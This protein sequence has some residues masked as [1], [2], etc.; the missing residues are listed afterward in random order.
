LR[1]LRELAA[2]SQ[3]ELR[4]HEMLNEASKRD[5]GNAKSALSEK[6][7]FGTS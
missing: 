2:D 7:A 5:L 4:D 6:C 3:N 1:L